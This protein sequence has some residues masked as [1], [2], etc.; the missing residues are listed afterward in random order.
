MRFLVYMLLLVSALL[1]S[2]P[3]E[4]QKQP[5]TDRPTKSQCVVCH[6]DVNGLIRLS[7]EVERIKPELKSSEISGEG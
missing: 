6:T 1:V 4:A 3:S 7:W 2:L 5:A